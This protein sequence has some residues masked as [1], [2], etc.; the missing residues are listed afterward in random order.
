MFDVNFSVRLARLL[1]NASLSPIDF[2]VWLLEA[3]L[4]PSA[5]DRPALLSLARRCVAERI[6]RDIDDA[7]LVGAS[8]PRRVC[9]RVRRAAAG[10]RFAPFAIDGAL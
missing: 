9:R 10:C 8:P 2:S 1:W 4:A 7:A 3:G 5:I 6:A